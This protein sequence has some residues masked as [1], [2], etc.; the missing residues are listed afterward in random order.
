VGSYYGKNSKGFGIY[1]RPLGGNIEVREHSIE[2][3]VS[4]FQEEHGIEV[5]VNQYLTCLENRFQIGEEWSHEMIQ[6]YTV[7]FGEPKYYE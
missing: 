1:N 4:E 5:D 7:S 3:V 2:K 6:I